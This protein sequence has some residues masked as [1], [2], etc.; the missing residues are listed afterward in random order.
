ME[1]YMDHITKKRGRK[2]GFRKLDAKNAFLP[3]VRC[4]PGFRTKLDNHL[5]NHPQKMSEF[6]LEAVNARINRENDND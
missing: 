6:I 2:L 3:S 1:N 4:H 5:V